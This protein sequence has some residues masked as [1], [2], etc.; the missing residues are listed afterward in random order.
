[1]FKDGDGQLDTARRTD[2]TA[3]RAHE[4]D[5]PHFRPSIVCFLIETD[6][7]TFSCLKEKE[8]A[9]KITGSL[10]QKACFGESL[11]C[12]NEGEIELYEDTLV[13]LVVQVIEY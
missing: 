5:R 12:S 9:C 6:L 2:D 1:M 4:I 13:E 10:I 11:S 7:N 3:A 8:D